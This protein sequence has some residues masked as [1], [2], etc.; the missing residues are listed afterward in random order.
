VIQFLVPAL[1]VI[2]VAL[3]LMRNR[4]NRAPTDSG[5]LS[6]GMLIGLIVIGAALAIGLVWALH[7][8]SS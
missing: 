1:I 8:G 6:F 4:P 3:V 7:V 2:I 5:P